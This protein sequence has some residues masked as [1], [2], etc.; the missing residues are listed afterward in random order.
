MREIQDK[1]QNRRRDALDISLLT[2]QTNKMIDDVQNNVPDDFQTK[3]N[4]LYRHMP[5]LFILL[6]EK[7]ITKE[8]IPFVLH[9]FKEADKVQIGEADAF[10]TDVSIGKTLAEKYIFPVIKK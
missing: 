1:Q 2:T 3:Y 5:S 8:Q 9:M 4:Y 10:E 6:K 7:S